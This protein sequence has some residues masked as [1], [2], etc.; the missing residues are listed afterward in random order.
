MKLK[1]CKMTR[2]ENK[3][4]LIANK[5]ALLVSFSSMIIL[6]RYNYSL[7]IAFIF[8]HTHHIYPVIF[9]HTRFANV[10]VCNVRNSL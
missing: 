5:P 6:K 4:K 8:M 9:K 1:L 3:H 7:L 2:H 10:D